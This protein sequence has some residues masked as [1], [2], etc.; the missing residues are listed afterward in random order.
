MVGGRHSQVAPRHVSQQP[1]PG[2]QPPPSYNQG[3]PPGGYPPNAAYPPPAYPP[4]SYPPG[5]PPPGVPPPGYSSAVYSNPQQ[6]QG[7]GHPV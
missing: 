6:G 2:Y 5:A 7:Y 1:Q 3:Y 4:P